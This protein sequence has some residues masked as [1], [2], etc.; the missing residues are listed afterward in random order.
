MIYEI[1]KTNSY[2]AHEYDIKHDGK[3]IYF[4]RLGAL[5]KYQRIKMESLK[6]PTVFL[7]FRFSGIL[8]Y[9]PFLHWFG[10]SKQKKLF[11]CRYGK[12]YIGSFARC[13][14]G[15]GKQRYLITT[16][17]GE[18]LYV[19]T[20]SK[21]RYTYACFYESDDQTQ[22]AQADTFL[23]AKNGCFTH[24]LYLLDD[25]NELSLLL[26]AFMLYYDNFE[27]TTRGK[28]YAGK[29]HTY[30]YTWGKYNEK[31]NEGWKYKYFGEG[32]FFLE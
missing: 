3:V 12:K 10:K 7:S 27:Y 11:K 20:I 23:T 1:Q 14:D 30:S 17:S 22:I 15:F 31:Y 26:L 29:S 19:Y 8:N 24:T 32:N 2:L 16:A 9:I 28:W 5:S 25:K 13:L 4:G 18:T 21:G 6:E